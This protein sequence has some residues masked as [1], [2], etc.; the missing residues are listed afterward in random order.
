MGHL[1]Q[2]IP[3]RPLSNKLKDL[4]HG[5]PYQ[6]FVMQIYE[7]LQFH[8]TPRVSSIEHIDILAAALI[9]LVEF[10]FDDDLGPY[11]KTLLA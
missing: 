7:I 10:W 4:L 8:I 2:N 11:V 1:V 6:A 5:K 3:P 9:C